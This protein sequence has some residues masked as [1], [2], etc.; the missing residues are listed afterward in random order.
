MRRAV[1]AVHVMPFCIG[2]EDLSTAAQ[3]QII[4]IVGHLTWR[5]MSLEKFALLVEMRKLRTML[6]AGIC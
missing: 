1:E 6:L 2:R 3:Y 4:Q 5:R